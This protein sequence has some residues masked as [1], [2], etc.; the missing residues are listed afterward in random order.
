M[1]RRNVQRRGSFVILDPTRLLKGENNISGRIETAR[2]VQGRVA[3]HVVLRQDFLWMRFGA[4]QHIFPA[5]ILDHAKDTGQVGVA[6]AAEAAL[7][8]RVNGVSSEIR[9]EVSHPALC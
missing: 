9:Q 5:S 7:R 6:N 8:K 4:S 2:H 3:R 1:A